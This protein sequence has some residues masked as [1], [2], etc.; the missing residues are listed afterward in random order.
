MKLGVFNH[1]WWKDACEVNAHEAALLPIAQYP[2]GNA[3]AADL[4]ARITNGQRVAQILPEADAEL[5]VDAGGTGLNFVVGSSGDQDLKL[6]HEVTGKLLCSHFIDPLTTSFQ[7]LNWDVVWQCLKS[8]HWIKAFWDRAAMV[9]LHRFGVPNVIHLPMAAPDRRYDTDPVDQSACKPV[10]SFVG[11]QNTMFFSSNANVPTADLFAGTLAHAVLAD[12]SGTTFYDIYHEL[13][14][15]GEPIRE[16]DSN[17]TQVQKTLAYFRAKLF[18]H[19]A[20]SIRNRDRFVIFLKRKLGETFHLV[21][22]GWDRAYGLPTQLPFPT[23]EGYLNHFRRTAINLNLV[24]GNAET[25]LNMRH[26]EIT[27]AGGFMLCYDQAELADHFTPGKECAV[28]ESEQDLL[29]KIQYYLSHPEER[30]AIA[31]AGQKRTLAQ[32]LYSHRLETLLKTVVARPLPVEYS[33]TTWREDFR[34]LMPDPDIVLDCGANRGQTAESLRNLYPRA[35]IYSF[36]PVRACFEDLEKTCAQIGVH[37]VHKA[38][39]DRDGKARIHLTA[40]PECHSLLAYQV[41]NPCAKWTWV[42]GEEEVDVCTLDHW[43]EHHQLDLGRVDIIKLDVQ[44]AELQ[45]LFGARKLLKTAKLIYLEVAF[46][47]IYKEA[48]LFEEI[49]VFMG[50]CGYRR[51][52]IY[53]SDQPHHWGDALYVKV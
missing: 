9:E 25:G 26:F 39:G 43:C 22:A 36:E 31:R 6:L 45:A 23:A 46:V 21:G 37:A 16:G 7:G 10:V 12:L 3:Y 48:P 5:L 18:F 2:S 33:T 30:A 4:G 11:G 53:P 1:G 32:H 14:G 51:A 13:Y 19:A 20:L 29:D 47:S 27:A 8:R 38:V 34:T 35:Q 41:G 42:V 49:E 15:L 28:F 44:G 17:E 50:E 24:N 40:S 52:A